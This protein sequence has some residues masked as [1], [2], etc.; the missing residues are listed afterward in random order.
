MNRCG[1]AGGS[2]AYKEYH[3]VEW[4]V[5]SHEDRHL[6]E[7]LILEGAQA[8][9]SWTTILKKRLTYRQAYQGFDPELVARFTA[10]DKAGLLANPGIVRNRLK[11]EASVTNAGAFLDVQ[12][13]YGSFAEYV[14]SFVGGQ[15]ITNTWASLAEIPA[16]TDESRALSKALKKRGFKFVGPTICYAFMQAVGM[17]NDHEVS[18][19]RYPQVAA[20]S[21]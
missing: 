3:D 4:G 6:F 5:P 8:G 12:S 16:E 17:V 9:L 1:W 14:W 19:F 11:V 20:L 15:P 7:M 21:G 10:A 2:A 13:Q 18:C